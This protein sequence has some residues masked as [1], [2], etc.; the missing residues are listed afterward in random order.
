VGL[1]ASLI[2]CRHLSAFARNLTSRQEIHA[3]PRGMEIFIEL[4]ASGH[5]P[6]KQL[7][8]PNACRYKKRYKKGSPR[9]TGEDP[10]S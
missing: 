5:I 8:N 3:I 1:F 2:L 9:N 6:L 4:G 7:A 10:F